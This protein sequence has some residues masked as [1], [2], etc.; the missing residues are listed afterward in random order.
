VGPLASGRSSVGAASGGVP[1]TAAFSPL[2]TLVGAIAAAGASPRGLRGG[3]QL[4]GRLLGMTRSADGGHRRS[5]ATYATKHSEHNKGSSRWSIRHGE[6]LK[7][8]VVA[9][10]QKTGQGV[11]ATKMQTQRKEALVK[12]SDDVENKNSAGD[13]L[14]KVAK[15]LGKLFVLTVVFDNGKVALGEGAKLLVVVEATSGVVP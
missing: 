8:K 6:L 15:I 11:C 10:L 2:A 14:A 13:V 9:D 7:S 4:C 3:R 5:G 1:T 12:T